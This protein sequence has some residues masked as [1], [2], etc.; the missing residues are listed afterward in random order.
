MS[1][2]CAQ[3]ENKTIEYK[4]GDKYYGAINENSKRHGHG[5]MTYADGD[6][7]DGEWEDDNQHGD[8]VYTWEDGAIFDGEFENGKRHG[9]VR[10]LAPPS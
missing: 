4:S 10:S 6:K 7:Y 9:R 5:V 1:Y 3:R 8:G 2:R